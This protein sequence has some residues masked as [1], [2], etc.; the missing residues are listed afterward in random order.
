MLTKAQEIK[1]MDE[2]DYILDGLLNNE[3]L[4]SLNL[5]SGLLKGRGI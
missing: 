4:E 1:Y 3:V 2:I 5:I